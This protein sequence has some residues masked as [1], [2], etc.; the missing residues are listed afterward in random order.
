MNQTRQAKALDK[1]KNMEV[2]QVSPFKFVVKG[3][4]RSAYGVIT[5]GEDQLQKRHPLNGN[6]TP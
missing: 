6:H 3:T 1:V 5:W 2:E 4:S